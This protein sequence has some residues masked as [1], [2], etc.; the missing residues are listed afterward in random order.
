MIR[1]LRDL[2]LSTRILGTLVILLLVTAVLQR[3]EGEPP[4][5]IAGPPVP[6][7]PDRITVL[8]SRGRVAL[9]REQ[10]QWL[11]ESGDQL[12]P[13]D[14]G[15]VDTLLQEVRRLDRLPVVTTRG[16][17]REYGLEDPVLRTVAIRGEEGEELTLELGLSTAAGDAVYGR[18]NRGR[19]IVRLPRALHSAVRTD[20]ADYRDM[21]VARIPEE[22]IR[23]ITI[24]SDSQAPLVVERVEGGYPWA[25]RGVLPPGQGEVREERFRDLFRELS[26][27]SAIGFPEALPGEH[28]GVGPPFVT[29]KVEMR[30]GA[31]HRMILYPPDDERRFAAESSTVAYPFQL[32]EWRVRRLLLGI[33]AY[34]E[35]FMEEPPLR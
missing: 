20:A 9:L 11:L 27:L 2:P 22:Q 30:E 35:P 26:S 3:L 33:E 23:R 34:L 1:L 21:V 24:E 25:V 12:L 10:Q 18:V 28:N 29:L 5:R 14:S 15:A 13:G 16:S 31:D 6:E 19:E 17:N 8:S 32:P 7:N 4:N